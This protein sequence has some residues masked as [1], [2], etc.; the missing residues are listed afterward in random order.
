MARFPDRQS[1][2]AIRKALRKILLKN[3]R[4]KEQEWFDRAYGHLREFY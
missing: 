4:H 1:L 2:S 3:K